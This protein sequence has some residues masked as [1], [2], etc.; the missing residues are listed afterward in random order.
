MPKHLEFDVS[1]YSFCR[2]TLQIYIPSLHL[3]IEYQGQTHYYTT[4]VYGSAAARQKSDNRKQEIAVNEGISLIQIPFWWD[5]SSQS[6]TA[7]IRKYRPD[8]LQHLESKALPI[9]T[10][11]ATHLQRKYEYTP[12]IAQVYDEEIDPK[13]W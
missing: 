7:T 3:A 8:L 12:N 4:S 2:L 1:F 13:G 6:L 9:P 10:Q 11:M 5:K